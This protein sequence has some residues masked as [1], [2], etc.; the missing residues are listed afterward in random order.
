[1]IDDFEIKFL[2]DIADSDKRR[3]REEALDDALKNTFPAYDPVSMEQL[4]PPAADRV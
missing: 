1:M 4:T 3:R 2:D